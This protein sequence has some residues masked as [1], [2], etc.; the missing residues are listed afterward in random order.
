MGAKKLSLAF[1]DLLPAGD[2]EAEFVASLAIASNDL[3]LTHKLL[4]LCWGDDFSAGER[5][6]LM[7]DAL[8]HVWETHLLVVDSTRQHPAVDAFVTQLADK[9]PGE[10]LSGEDLVRTLRG[11][12]GATAPKLRNVLRLARLTVAHYPKPGDERLTEVLEA[13]AAEDMAADVE[14]DDTMASVRSTFADEISHRLALGDLDEEGWRELLADLSSTVLAII[15]L[16][17]TAVGLRYAGAQR[18]E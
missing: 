16:A 17:D 15:H 8:L 18:G 6:A 10:I 7:R 1:R 3:R 2:P 4:F 11:E 13:L 12:A 9:Y 5:L 14:F